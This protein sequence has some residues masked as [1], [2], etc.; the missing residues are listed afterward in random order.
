MVGRSTVEP[1]VEHTTSPVVD[2]FL[3]A[4]L[5][6]PPTRDEWVRRSRLL[7]QLDSALSRRLTLVAA[8]AGYGKTTLVAQWIA[9]GRS[10]AAAWVSLD[11]GD[12]DAGRLWTHIAASLERAGC[13]I[14][15]DLFTIMAAG[16]AEALTALLPR[17]V[18]AL[19]AMP[20]DIVLVLDDFHLVTQPACHEQVAFLVE[21]LPA[22]AHLVV[23]TRADPSL[24][25]GRLRVEGNLAEIRADALSFDAAEAASLMAH[26]DV[27]L[28]PDSL[29]DLLKRTEGWP[30][31]LYLA[32]LSL[33]G[34]ADPDGF[35]RD[36]TGD[37]RFLGDYLTEEVLNRHSEAERDF[38]ATMSI[39]ERFSAPLG[40]Y[41]A[42]TTG[43]A[44]MLSDF[45]RS[46]LFLIP[47]DH[48]RRWFRFHHLFAAVARSEFESSQPERVVRLHHRAAEW[49]RDHGYM[50]EAVKHFLAAGDTASAAYLVQA[51]WFR[52]VDA[53]RATTVAG[54]L[55][56]LGPPAVASDPAA[57]V[58]AAWM[59]ALSGDRDLFARLLENLAQFSDFGPLPDGTASVEAAISILRGMFGFGGPMEMLDAA[60]R[61]V[62][63]EVDAR[64]PFYGAAH[65]ALGHAGYVLGDLD[66]AVHH[67]R[68]AAYAEA[69]PSIVQVL[70][71]ATAAFAE[72]ERGNDLASQQHAEQAMAIVDVNGFAVMPQSSFGFIAFGMM[73][74]SAG[75]TADA[76]KTL[77]HCLMLRRKNAA[78]S[79]WPTIHLSRVM[80]SVAIDARQLDLA[81]TMLDE[82]ERLLSDFDEGVE[83]MLA[84]F[85]AIRARLVAATGSDPTAEHLTEREIEIL[86]L[87]PD[88]LSISEIARELYLSPNTI[89]THTRSIYRKL[90]ATSRA[91]A[92]R[93]ARGRRLI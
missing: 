46:N 53:G 25:L 15:H 12:N 4:K 28:T 62:A 59:A 91:E 38:V 2:A 21:H 43:T 45:E 92:V 79:P 83:T 54:W 3:E 26:E 10:P 84:R 35:V 5:H 1:V 33:V 9:G 16:S 67:A 39:L 85:A 69:T 40:D 71:H 42:E 73:Q 14:D 27:P 89:K 29:A 77:D 44:S 90:G 72:A 82:G 20:D 37:N 81:R 87:L 34:R 58:T 74:A 80:A 48:D 47:L 65:A 8:P 88:S 24:R 30:A 7:D 17:L 41:V 86:T 75:K 61:G 56:A 49:F 31:G 64:S 50:D 51:N 76:L 32:A 11:E 78:L 36:F 63:L 93:I 68:I 13:V 6:A 23:L 66:T 19:A 70:G 55:Q 57:G 52:Y 18:N 60:T 22:Q